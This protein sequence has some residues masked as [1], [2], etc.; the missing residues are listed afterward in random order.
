MMN[1]LQKLLYGVRHYFV[2]IMAR[3]V[4]GENSYTYSKTVG[5][6]IHAFALIHFD[7]SGE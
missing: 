1:R 2:C 6:Y 4:L 7:C 3:S 5:H